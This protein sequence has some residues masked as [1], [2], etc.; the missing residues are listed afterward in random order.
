MLLKDGAGL[1]PV[2]LIYYYGFFKGSCSWPTAGFKISV[3]AW[4][5]RVSASVFL[6]PKCGLISTWCF[7]KVR[8]KELMMLCQGAG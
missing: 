8:V 2:E 6:I 5:V 1:G 4:M 7:M 3:S